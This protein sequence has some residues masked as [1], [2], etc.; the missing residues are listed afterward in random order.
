MLHIIQTDTSEHCD[1]LF[2][3]RRQQLLDSLHL[4]RDFSVGIDIAI[5]NLHLHAFV[6]GANIKA[7]IV[8]G[9]LRFTLVGL[10][11][12]LRHEADETVPRAH[13]ACACREV[14][15]ECRSQCEVFAAMLVVKG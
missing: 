5:D 1:L 9:I 6:L 11:I 10:S 12:F 8:F 3:D 13:V 4:I 2:R 7:C 14:A 15:T